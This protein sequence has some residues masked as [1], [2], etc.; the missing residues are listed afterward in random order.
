M[1]EVSKMTS[2][3]PSLYTW[4][5]IIICLLLLLFIS[6]PLY[7]ITEIIN[8]VILSL[9]TTKIG[10][11]IASQDDWALI[12]KMSKQD[13]LHNKRSSADTIKNFEMRSS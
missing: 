12:H 9:L 1:Y 13:I 6:I 2:L 3:K 4:L 8:T 7:T 11:K 5:F 10:S